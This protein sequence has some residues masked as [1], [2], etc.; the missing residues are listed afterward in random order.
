M[1]AARYRVEHRTHYAHPERVT[2]S[3]HVMHL[4][5][6]RLPAQEVI[7]YELA[8]E[9]APASVSRRV[10]Y[11]GNAVH[12]VTLLT[13]YTSLT[14]ISRAEVVVSERE[15]LLE[16]AFDVPHDPAWEAVRDGIRR[17]ERAWAPALV[18]FC[19]A[20]PHI[21][22]SPA[23]EAFARLA[24]TPG[25]PIGDAARA[26]MRYI[27]EEFTFLPHETTIA[28]SVE[29]VLADRHGVCQDLAHLQIAAMRAIGLPARYVSGYLLTDP[30]P[31][32][33][34]LTGADASHAWVSAYCAGEGWVDLDPTNG[35][36]ADARHVTIGWGRDYDD[37]SPLRGVLLGGEAHTLRVGVSVIPV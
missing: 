12:H 1:A 31:G 33:A 30:P 27:H 23:L 9:P 24:F 14:V 15:P 18:E 21:T 6:R 8:I 20:S 25:R 36:V 4:E 34:R 17:R 22:T 2:T 37:V 7:D 26:L 28:T 16:T 10:D 13:P 29:Q 32:Q 3:T 5:P 35:C 19:A 11:F